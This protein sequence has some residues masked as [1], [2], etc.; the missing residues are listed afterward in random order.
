[1]S[2]RNPLDKLKGWA[3]E[4]LRAVEATPATVP[5]ESMRE[6]FSELNAG[7][8]RN[9]S[10]RRGTPK[11]RKHKKF[12]TAQELAGLPIGE[13]FDAL[14]PGLSLIKRESGIATWSLIYRVI[15]DG[16]SKQRRWKLGRLDRM[17]LREARLKVRKRTDD[18]VGDRKLAAYVKAQSVIAEASVVSYEELVTKY[19][20]N[21]AKPKTRYWQQTASS[22]RHARFDAWK[23]LPVTQIGSDIIKQLHARIESPSVANQTKILLHMLFQYGVREKFITVNPVAVESRKL[24]ARDR[25]LT[26]AEIRLVW[27]VPI[28]RL[29][30]LLVQR[31]MNI[32]AILRKEIGNES[33]DFVWYIP[34]EKF[35][36]D[37]IHAVPLCK[38]ALDTLSNLPKSDDSDRY[39][40]S[41]ECIG[42][43]HKMEQLGVPD[44][45]PKDIQRT[46]RTRL[47]ALG[48]PPEIAERV[49]G[50]NVGNSISRIYDR[51]DYLREKREA[52][53]KLEKKLLEIVGE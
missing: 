13:S 45:K 5:I 12:R 40:T 2:I 22:L 44:A 10:A 49:Q 9:L 1:M 50:H 37:R 24:K 30:L 21:Y 25:T 36:L 4:F 23:T 51:H 41:R 28:F 31:P 8:R 26:N 39:F 14:T 6:V 20:V 52:I 19:I 46:G 16:R 11:R 47:G 17:S 7:L 42:L 15:V 27:P 38:T 32:R 33:G 29:G 48:V 18:P 3:A 34:A 53:I 43:V 35:K